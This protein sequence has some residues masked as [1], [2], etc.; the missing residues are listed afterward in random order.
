M[1]DIQT[2]TYDNGN[3]LLVGCS[4]KSGS[5]TAIAMLAYPL[6]GEIKYRN[7]R[8]PLMAQ[9]KWR[10]CNL[11]QIQSV[12][13]KDFPVRIAIIRDPVERFISA[14][15]DRVQQRNKDNTRDW[16]PDFNFFLE[17]IQQIRKKSRDIKNH[18]QPQTKSLGTSADF[19]TEVIMTAEIN[20]K[21]KLRIEEVSQIENVPTPREKN[22]DRIAP[23]IPSSKQ[24]DKIKKLF[25]DDYTVWGEYFNS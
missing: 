17:N 6:L 3:K 9:G 20:T 23:V 11:L 21:L 19:Y 16:I 12:A 22:S 18:T 24:I 4:N 1:P 13:L 25:R 5:S 8:R 2:I 7:E 14:Y 15:K 10:E